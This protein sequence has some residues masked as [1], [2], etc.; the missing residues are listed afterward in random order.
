MVSYRVG[1]QDKQRRV[2]SI[3]EPLLSRPERVEP[4]VARWLQA[5]A[6]ESIGGLYISNSHSAH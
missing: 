1:R 4:S 3:G 2:N 6:T 5:T